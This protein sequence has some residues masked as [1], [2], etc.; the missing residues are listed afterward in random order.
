MTNRSLGETRRG[1]TVMDLLVAT[2]VCGIGACL[3]LPT[4]LEKLE[5]LK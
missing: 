1:L 3:L 4:M 5:P 2:A